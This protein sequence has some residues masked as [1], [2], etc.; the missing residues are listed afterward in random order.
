MGETF[1]YVIVGGGSAGCVLAN[2][3]SADPRVRV[4]LVEAGPPDRNPFIHIPAGIIPVIRSKRLNW[5]FWTTPQK[6]CD[7]R[8]MYWPRGRTLGGSSAINAMCYIRGVPWDY[9]H[10]AEQGCTG[11][12]WQDV[13]PYFRKLE[14]FEAIAKVPEGGQLHATGGPLNVAEYRDLNPL[15]KAFVEAAEQAGFQRNPDFNGPVQEGV[16]YYHVMQRGGERCSNARAYLTPVRGRANLR[17]ITNAHV[18]RLLFE[19]R[20]AAGVR[21]Y[22]DG[23]YIDLYAG[24]ETLLCAGAIGSPQ[25]LLLS[26]IGPR[27][28][29]DRHAIHQVQELPG[30]GENLQDHLDVHVTWLD[31]SRNAVSFHPLS[32]GR[33]VVSLFRFLFGRRGEFTSNFAQAGGFFK[34]DPEQPRPDLQWHFVPFVFVKHGQDLRPV[35]RH[36]AYTLM[37]CFLR[38]RSRGRVR[39]ASGDPFMP[40]AIDPAYL[41]DPADLP[42]LLAGVKRAREV[43]RQPAFQRYARREWQPGEAVQTDEQLVD[44][45]RSHAETIYHPV[46]T[47]RMGSDDAAVV[48]PRLR[49]RGVEGLRVVDASIMPTLIGGNTNAPTTMI[50]EKAADMILEDAGR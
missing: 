16:G 1:D 8:P 24:R 35:F 37:T 12:S 5:H 11:W 47:C 36:Y 48:D 34:S 23:R 2:R 27:E 31:R 46:G 39:L 38:P 43:L 17:V 45:V 7:E 29:L 19:G 33:Y 20:R 15:M 42:P 18:T 9:D 41:S 22:R 13:L 30:V 6:Q 14:N 25:L 4:C 44:Y 21:Y 32:W 49:V 10:W 28:E 3:L 40:P 26:G 50:A